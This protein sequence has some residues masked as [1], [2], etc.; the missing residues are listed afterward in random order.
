MEITEREK[1]VLLLAAR[2]SIKSFFEDIE[3]PVPDYGNNTHLKLFLGA[4]VTLKIADKLRGCIGYIITKKPLF[5]TVCD[6]AKQAAFRDPRF[7]S[8]TSEELDQ[9][10]IEI[11]VLSQ[12][13]KI[14]EYNEIIIGKHGLIL[15]SDAVHAVLLPQVAVTNNFTTEQFL[16]ALCE[17]G[18]LFPEYWKV[19]KLDL[20][21]FT[22]NIFSE[23]DKE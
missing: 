11:S 6:A 21:V 18:G 3:I 5:D 9:V 14:N 7:L 17:K 20:H 13:Q 22:A 15:H 23:E 8:L 10:S 12:P 2:Q 16:S 4:F 1:K 19:H